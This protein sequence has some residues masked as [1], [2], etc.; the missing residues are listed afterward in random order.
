MV[1]AV[2]FRL[3]GIANKLCGRGVVADHQNGRSRAHAPA[4]PA[5]QWCGGMVGT[6]G[7]RWTVMQYLRP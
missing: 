2:P 5:N 1:H 6:A 7:V 3:H 4:L